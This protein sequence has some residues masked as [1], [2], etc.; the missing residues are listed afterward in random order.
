MN[1]KTKKLDNKICI[2]ITEDNVDYRIIANSYN[3][4]DGNTH[5]GADSIDTRG[6]NDSALA[7]K[8][9]I[10]DLERNHN[11]IVDFT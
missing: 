4:G 11:I 7:K 9:I 6:F 1:I 10:L 5:I 3:V 2:D 8:R